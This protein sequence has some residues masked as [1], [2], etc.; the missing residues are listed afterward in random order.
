MIFMNNYEW[1]LFDADETLFH[2]DAF[3]GLQRM[4]LGFDLDFNEQDYHAYQ[5]TNKSLWVAY[6]QGNISA[7]HLQQARFD[8]WSKKLEVPPAD[9]NDAFLEVMAD[10]SEPIDGAISLLQTLKGHTKLGIVTNGFT[11]LQ[12][13]RLDRT[14]LKDYFDILVISEQVGVAKPHIDIFE[15]ALSAMGW[16]DKEKVLMV[17]DT[18]ETDILGAQNAGLHTCWLNSTKKP[19]VIEIEPNYQVSSLIE[20]E[21]RFKLEKVVES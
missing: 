11:Q 10:I 7:Q 9:L 3:R 18:L 20:L 1:V 6:Q 16:P 15:H 8:L 12:Q 5:V 2:F 4:F 19:N 21:Q 17:G 14:G 13:K